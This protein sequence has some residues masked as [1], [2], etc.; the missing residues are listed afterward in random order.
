MLKKVSNF[1]FHEKQNHEAKIQ[2]KNIIQNYPLLAI[3]NKDL[4]NSQNSQ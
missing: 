3:H 2:I 4:L 1:K